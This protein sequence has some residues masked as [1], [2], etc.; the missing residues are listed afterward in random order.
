MEGEAPPEGWSVFFA[1]GEEE[2]KSHMFGMRE[3]CESEES[4]AEE[5]KERGELI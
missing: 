1:L 3:Y 4:G 2:P 5:N